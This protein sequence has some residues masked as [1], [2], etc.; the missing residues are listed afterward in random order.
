M[1]AFHLTVP[2]LEPMVDSEVLRPRLETLLL[3]HAENLWRVAPLEKRVAKI[4]RQYALQVRL[5]ANAHPPSMYA[6][7]RPL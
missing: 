6:G 1:H 5:G 4:V 3:F 2:Q 7:R